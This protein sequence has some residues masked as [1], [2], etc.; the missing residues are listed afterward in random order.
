MTMQGGT[1]V[2]NGVGDFVPY[3]NVIINGVFA[4]DTDWTKSDGTW[5]ISGGVA[6]GASVTT[7]TLSQTV[8]PLTVGLRYKVKYDLTI[9]AG[10]IRVSDGVTN[11]ITR[12]VSGHYEE[13]LTAGATG[14][15]FSSPSSNF[16]GTI[17]NVVVYRE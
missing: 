11:G 4:A 14:L 6:N 15:I 17:D 5:T 3:P 9:S 16:T 2:G 8:P 10:D 1:G 7:G 13:Y 12:T